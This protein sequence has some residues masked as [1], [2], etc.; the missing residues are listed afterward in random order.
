VWPRPI[1][2]PESKWTVV[3]AFI[4][5]VALCIGTVAIVEMKQEQAPVE[6]AQHLEW[7]L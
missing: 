4:L 5:A 3:A 7:P 6:V 1:Y 2:K